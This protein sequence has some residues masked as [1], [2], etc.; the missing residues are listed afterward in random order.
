MRLTAKAVERLHHDPA[1][2]AQQD[3]K[4]DATTGLYLR[5]Y[6]S[7]RVWVYRYKLSGKVRVLMLG[8]TVTLSLADAR[9]S[10]REAHAKVRRGIDP[11]AEAQRAKAEA[12]RMPTVETFMVEY[13][14]RYAKPNKK[15]WAGDARLLNREVAPVMGRLRLD[16]VHRRDVIALL[17]AIRDRGTMVLSN[18]VLAVVR[19]MFNFAV[20]RAVLEHTPVERIKA[21]RETPRERVLSDEELKRLWESTGPEAQHM[22]PATRLALRLLLLTGQRAGEVCGMERVELNLDRG[23]WVLP[24]VRTKNSLT[25]TVPLSG[26]ALDTVTEALGLSWSPQWVFPAARGEGSLTVYGLD[27]AMQRIFPV[28]RPTP[29]DLRRTVGTRLGELGANRLVQDKVLNHKDRTVGGIYDRHS[30]DRDKRT[31]LEAWARRLE[32]IIANTVVSLS[33]CPVITHNVGLYSL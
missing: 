9:Q 1:K 21:V 18:R 25:H 14:D 17:D 23:V 6:A 3:I 8:D 16:Q 10:A 11:G 19:R 29:H 24:G 31:W 15:S 33:P 32:S 4:D 7:G 22:H 30:Y 28:D 27:Q 26:L 12:R 20:E 2:G 13:I 5:A